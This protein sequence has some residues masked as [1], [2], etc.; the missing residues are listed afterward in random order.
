MATE[1]P[2]I[3]ASLEVLTW[4]RRECPDPGSVLMDHLEGRRFHAVARGESGFVSYICSFHR[5][6]GLPP[7]CA[8]KALDA[9]RKEQ[10]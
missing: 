4:I 1:Q 10:R 7:S 3:A 9:L 8:Q 5:M 6:T 2:T